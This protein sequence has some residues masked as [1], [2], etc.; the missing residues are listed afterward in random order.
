MKLKNP[1]ILAPM[2]NY[3]DLAFRLLCRKYGASLAYTEQVS[4]IALS[5]ENRKTLSMI[6]TCREDK[7]ISLQLSGRDKETLLK[8][9]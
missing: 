5:K 8:G 2:A 6:K 4:A 7:P 3:S 9:L 1:F